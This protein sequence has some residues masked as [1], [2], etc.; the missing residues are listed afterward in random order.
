MTE[1][2]SVKDDLPTTEMWND[3]ADNSELLFMANYGMWT[4]Y[5]DPVTRIFET[6]DFSF[7]IDDGVNPPYEG[8]V[9]H[10][11]VIE[12]PKDK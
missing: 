4:G 3:Y 8:L 7:A 11:A 1:W 10:W 2:T 5:Y 6:E 9:T 12:P